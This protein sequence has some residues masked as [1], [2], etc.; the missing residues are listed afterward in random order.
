[1]PG[2]KRNKAWLSIDCKPDLGDMALCNKTMCKDY[3]ARNHE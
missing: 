1:M 2:N 3:V